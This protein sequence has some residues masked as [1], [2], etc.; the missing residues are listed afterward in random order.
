M[1]SIMIKIDILSY[2]I[3][4]DHLSDDSI[5]I[6]YDQNM[7]VVQAKGVRYTKLFTNIL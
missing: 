6:I 2:G 1:P 3:T 5:G 4:Y 7:F